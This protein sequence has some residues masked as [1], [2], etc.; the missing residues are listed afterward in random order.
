MLVGNS[1]K[2]CLFTAP[3]PELRFRLSGVWLEGILS[4][5]LI[6]VLSCVG[7]EVFSGE[8]ST[9]SVESAIIK[10]GVK[11]VIRVDLRGFVRL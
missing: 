10:G 5:F 3:F 8:I 9:K 2:G 4:R 11:S 7:I 1:A 6:G